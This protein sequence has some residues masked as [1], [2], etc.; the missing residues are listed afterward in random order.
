MITKSDNCLIMHIAI[1]KVKHKIILA[2][3]SMILQPIYMYLHTHQRVHIIQQEKNCRIIIFFLKYVSLRT[4][5]NQTENFE[6]CI[7]TIVTKF[8]K[9]YT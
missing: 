8:V 9:S 1:I 5:Y 6:N 4:T 3:H 7:V 2:S